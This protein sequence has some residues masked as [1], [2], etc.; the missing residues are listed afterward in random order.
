MDEP[1][2]L[3]DPASVR[4]TIATMYLAA[5]TVDATLGDIQLAAHQI[6]AAAR[7]L[8]LVDAYGGALL[9]DATGLGKTFV[10]IAVARRAM[11]ALVVAP[12][13]L[14]SMWRESL[15]RAATHA[16]VVSYESLSR[17]TVVE[18]RYA[19][20]ILDEAHHA[21]NP[22]SRRYA[23]LAEVTWGAK[24][25]LLTATPVH[26]RARDIGSL[27]AL[28][29]GSCAFSMS[30]SEMSRFIV[31][32]G[33]RDFSMHDE[34]PRLAK[35]QWIDVPGNAETLHAIRSLPPAVPPADGSVAHALLILG[36]IRAWTSSEFALRAMLKRRLRRAAA[37][38]SALEGGHQPAG[39]ELEAWLTFDD[40]IQL[41]FPELFAADA[42][43]DVPSLSAALS[44]HVEGVRVVLRALDGNEGLTDKSRIAT[45]RH[46]CDLHAS[47][48]VVAFTQ[49][50]DTARAMFRATAVVGGVALVTGSGARVASGAVAVDEIVRGFDVAYDGQPARRAFPLRL[51]IATDVLSEGLSL[52]RAGVLVHLDLPWT[53][54]RL[55][56]RVG[57]LRRLGSNHRDIHVYAI[58][59]PVGARELVQVIRALQRK[60]RLSSGIV[61]LSETLPLLG[62]R[63]HRAAQ[64]KSDRECVEQ[65]RLV[66]SRW[67]RNDTS[68]ES[69]DVHGNG[70]V[71]VGLV[72]NGMTFR[73]VAI[74][75]T[76]VSETVCDVLRVARAVSTSQRSAGQS[77]HLGH[78]DRVVRAWIEQQRARELVH[79]TAAASS[80]VH[81]RVLSR[82]NE[83]LDSARRADRASSGMRVARL[84]ELVSA[85]RGVGAERAMQALLDRT[86]S[87]DL[88]ALELL[89]TRRV[90]RRSQES[91]RSRLE[92]I[93]VVDPNGDVVGAVRESTVDADPILT[94]G[95]RRPGPRQSSKRLVARD[96]A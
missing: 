29:L 73:L 38:A 22:R 84:R 82:L 77:E 27:L 17:G 63:L 41:G 46:V 26:N 64:R 60:T 44:A 94:A 19:L 90:S 56:Q 58:G 30:Q 25:L 49:F 65:L 89:L 53:I 4:R 74:E 87:L 7:I 52:R 33:A 76:R 16:D 48:P 42:M 9:A 69:A 24:V 6:D 71:G 43:V 70:G 34:L 95:L 67:V 11:P 15:G 72:S 68:L 2:T 80:D 37:F 36:L 81:A 75:A 85:A 20:I 14:R 86:Q 93:L 62:P 78:A 47:V 59:P 3:A 12:A 35:P 61:G 28:F 88:D 40:A 10:A 45:L 18:Q 51:L 23:A 57:R 31:R 54:A 8:T 39:R 21:R 55:E 83:H 91:T 66:L 92:A 79:S 13:A 50:A 1:L 96:G 5:P 32:R